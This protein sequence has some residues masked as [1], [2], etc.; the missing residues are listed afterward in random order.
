MCDH[1]SGP[2][3]DVSR[4][5]Q[6]GRRRSGATRH[7]RAAR[8][9]S[10]E[11]PAVLARGAARESEGDTSSR[12]GHRGIPPLANRAHSEGEKSTGAARA[13]FLALP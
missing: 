3:V 2:L 10:G 8:R 4:A 7:R 9:C 12:E 6:D 13:A 5:L 11:L 1:P